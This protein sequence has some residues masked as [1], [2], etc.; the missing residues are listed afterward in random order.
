M[1]AQSFNDGIFIFNALCRGAIF[2]N[3]TSD[4]DLNKDSLYGAILRK[5]NLCSCGVFDWLRK[6]TVP[7][8]LDY[9]LMYYYSL[10][11]V[12]AFDIKFFAW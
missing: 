9:I 1:L 6:D 12:H 11:F 10:F 4:V 3:D 8:Q 2:N 5:L 7:L